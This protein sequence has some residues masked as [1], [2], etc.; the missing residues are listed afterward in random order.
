M[1]LN[2]R[3]KKILVWGVIPAFLLFFWL[4]MTLFYT[5]NYS[6]S[7]LAQ[8]Y[9]SR[10]IIKF[11]T[12]EL[13]KNEKITGEFKAKENNLGIVAVRFFNFN[14]IS[15]DYVKF[16]LFDNKS[17]KLIYEN[18]YKVDQ[19]QPNQFFTFG[20][21]LISDSKNRDFR[22]EIIST[23]GKKGN[24][25]GLSTLQPSFAAQYQ[26]SKADLLNNKAQLPNFFI[27]K[28]YY[29]FSDIDTVIS[30][31]IYLLPF[32]IYLIFILFKDTSINKKK[33]LLVFMHIITV[34]I[35]VLFIEDI[36]RLSELVLITLWI[37]LIKYYRL[38]SS[39]SYLMALLFLTTAPIF[40]IIGRQSSAENAAVW[41]YFF[42]VI[43]TVQLGFELWKKPKIL[44]TYDKF[45]ENI[46]GEKLTKKFNKAKSKYFRDS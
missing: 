3:F 42:M 19:F 18:K 10:N 44:V 39:V 9:G 24:A 13:L 38:E 36:N 30:S 28:L 6:L 11:N 45:L 7:V 14:R 27:K 8:N 29:P 2:K 1:K 5:T 46:F 31:L 23:Q 33:Y 22:F 21:P 37:V 32:I 25:I 43:G 15:D 41:T 35:F 40:I 16:L 20:F 34:T 12:N 26:F 4:F 17:G